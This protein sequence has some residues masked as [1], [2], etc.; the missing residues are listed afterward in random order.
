MKP[1]TKTFQK[2]GKWIEKPSQTEVFVCV[3][4]NKYLRT[5]KLQIMCLACVVKKLAEDQNQK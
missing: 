4:G 1:A 5:R 2:G 3:C